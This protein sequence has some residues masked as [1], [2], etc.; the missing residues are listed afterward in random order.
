MIVDGFEHYDQW[1]CQPPH[2][3]DEREPE[4]PCEACER[5]VEALTAEIG[6]RDARIEALEIEL[7]ELRM[8][9]DTLQLRFDAAQSL[10]RSSAIGFHRL[11]GRLRAALTAD[12]TDAERLER[13]TIALDEV[14]Q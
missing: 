2:D 5:E 6:Q 13:I 3:P 14:M 4:E 8:D 11:M 12:L 7:A 1:R 9:R 10:T